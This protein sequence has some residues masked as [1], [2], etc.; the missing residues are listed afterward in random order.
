MLAAAMQTCSAALNSTAT[1]V[2]YDIVKRWR[3]LTGDHTLVKIG[4]W[5][6]AVATVLAIVLSPVFGHYE[7]IYQGIQIMVCYIAPP[8]TAVFLVGV[9][10]KGAGGRAAFLTMVIGALIGLA[11][12]VFDFFK[13]RFIGEGAA[14][15]QALRDSGFYRFLY[16]HV[17]NDFMLA[18]FGIFCVC[19][20]VLIVASM[21][22]R[23]P[24]KEEARPLVWDH[25]TDPVRVKC[26]SGLSDYRVMSAAVLIIFTVLYFIFR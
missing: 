7:T 1:L 22:F 5:T 10:W 11:C 25:W 8:I 2:A 13:T 20:A 21:V 6:T 18:S 19:V 4:R 17:L 14:A 9:F 3:P 26:G 24:L 23:E 16:K 12:F 15:E